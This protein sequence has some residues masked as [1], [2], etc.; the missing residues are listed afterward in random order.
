M[1][2]GGLLT[3][4]IAARRPRPRSG[5]RS[6]GKRTCATNDGLRRD[7]APVGM[8]RPARRSSCKCSSCITPTARG[9]CASDRRRRVAPARVGS[10]TPPLAR[11]GSARRA[12][13]PRSYCLGTRT[14]CCKGNMERD[15]CRT[16]G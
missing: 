5:I 8:G 12:V 16:M 3:S 15:C 2:A 7:T 1:F 9:S 13:A 11:G 10:R 14:C 4:R 6:G